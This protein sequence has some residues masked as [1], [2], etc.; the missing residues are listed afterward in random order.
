MGWSQS[1]Q[2]PALYPPPQQGGGHSPGAY[3]TQYAP[4]LYSFYCMSSISF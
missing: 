3:A 1:Q 2:N 4:G